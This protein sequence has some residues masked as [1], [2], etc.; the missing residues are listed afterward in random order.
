MERE[1]KKKALIWHYKAMNLQL[2]SWVYM[3][4]CVCWCVCVCVCVCVHISCMLWRKEQFEG[5][6]SFRPLDS[7]E[8]TQVIS[9][10]SKD[11]YFLLHI[12]SSLCS[13]LTKVYLV[14]VPSPLPNWLWH[15]VSPLMKYN[16]SLNPY[17]IQSWILARNISLKYQITNPSF[18]EIEMNY[19]KEQN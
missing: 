11:F 19:S 17:P 16:W 13:L 7:S 9:P 3:R 2:Y 15:Q 12:L 18:Q 14:S 8:G 6:C 4:T 10:G 1:F 5:I